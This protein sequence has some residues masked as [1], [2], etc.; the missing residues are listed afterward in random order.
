M[1]PKPFIGAPRTPFMGVSPVLLSAGVDVLASN[2]AVPDSGLLSYPFR[3]ALWIEEIR[4]DTR[5]ITGDN[6]NLGAFIYA[7]MQLGQKYL[8]RNPI[9][10]WL[11]GTT[12]ATSLEQEIDG[13]LSSQASFSHYRWRL[14]EP[15]YVEAGEVLRSVFSRDADGF[16]STNVQV[17]YVGKTAA[18][19][20]AVPKIIAVPYAAAF[21][22]P[23]G[24]FGPPL[25]NYAQ[26]NENHL[27]NPF[28]KTLRVQRLTGRV[29]ANN[30]VGA[31]SGVGLT[32]PTVAGGG[33]T[34]LMNDS[35]GG[36][37]V[38][39]NTAPGD[40]F[41]DLR[42]AWTVDTLMP[43]KGVYEVRAWNIDA[44]AT[45]HVGLIGTRDEAL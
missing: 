15:L 11:L 16:G 34:I 33:M 30:R 45:L 29:L 41:D 1:A 20:Q 24:S 10:I 23:V 22:T 44:D 37:M 38:N 28:S 27:F 40:V 43:P 9:P 2:S 26:S 4:W 19:D 39:S 8:M 21:I 7:H 14:P 17:T 6:T 12:M 42:G 5:A 32:T 36:K 31:E 25:V 3:K 18:P 13:E 35:W